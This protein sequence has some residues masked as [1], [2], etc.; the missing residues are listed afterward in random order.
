MCTV[1]NGDQETLLL[2]RSR[3]CFVWKLRVRT[4]AR[5]VAI[6]PLACLW[7][8]QDGTLDGTLCVRSNTVQIKCLGLFSGGTDSGG[9]DRTD[10]RDNPRRDALDRLHQL[11]RVSLNPCAAST[12]RSFCAPVHGFC[13]VVIRGTLRADANYRESVTC[14]TP[15][16]AANRV[17]LIARGPTNRCRTLALNAVEYC[18]IISP[19]LCPPVLPT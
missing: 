8:A 19:N 15:T 9:A 18:V 6:V 11:R 3:Q 7:R 13:G 14:G 17:A 16:S 5:R 12:T 10:G 2:R 1:G 4:E